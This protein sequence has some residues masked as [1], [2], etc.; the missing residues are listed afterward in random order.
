M[1]PLSRGKVKPPVQM[2]HDGIQVVLVL[3]IDD[4][5]RYQVRNPRQ[6]GIWIEFAASQGLQYLVQRH[7]LELLHLGRIRELAR[8]RCRRVQIVNLLK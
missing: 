5:Q 2:T 6:R 3:C 7:Q 4:A 8:E 1:S